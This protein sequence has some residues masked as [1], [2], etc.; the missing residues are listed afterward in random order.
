VAS[1]K[2]EK[3][4]EI[5]ASEIVNEL[6]QLRSGVDSFLNKFERFLRLD[7]EQKSAKIEGLLYI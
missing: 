3:V 5:K 7:S 4:E 2:E 1:G 6:R